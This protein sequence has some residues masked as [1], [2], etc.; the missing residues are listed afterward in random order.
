M[1][2]GTK[3]LIIAFSFGMIAVSFLIGWWAK[4][5]ITNVQSFFGGTGLLGPVT[6]GLSAMSGIASAFAIV[7]IPGIVYALGNSMTFWMLS[8][9]AFA[10]SFMVIGKKIRGMAELGPIASL[11]D[12]SDLRFNNNK[13]IKILLSIVLFVGSIAYLAAQIDACSVLFGHLLGWSPMVAGFVIFGILTLYMVL[14]GEVGGALTQ[15]FQGFVMVVASLVLLISFFAITKGF[16]PVI[17]VVS[18][19]GTV[20][21]GELTKTFIPDSMNAYGFAPG[22]MAMAWM[23]IPIL[24]CVGQPQ[25]LVRMYGINDP[26]QM[27]KSGAIATV[28]HMVVGF[29]A[30]VVGYEALYLVGKGLIP[31]L[32]NGDQAIFAVAD[33]IG[34]YAQLFV[35]A[36]ILA[37][38]MSSASMF[39]SMSSTILSRDL[40]DAFGIKVDPKKQINISR[41][42][43]IVLGILSI[44]FA[45]TSSEMVAILGT[46]GWGTLM[47]ATFPVFIVGLLWKK[48][49]SKGVLS[50]LAV[51]LVLNVG[52]LILSST[53]F[54]WPGG[55]PWYVTVVAAAIVVTVFVSLFTKEELDKRIEAVID[56]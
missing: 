4:R 27:P 55:L 54:N 12:I 50:G 30:V 35:Y 41:V 47:S 26:T 29:F 48:A 3:F 25:V 34:V 45:L 42:T 16:G 23:L 7:G 17:E 37:A 52:S 8:S 36:A 56:L 49:T 6:V 19:A 51:A 2:A 1:T 24:G 39:L 40:P 20:T 21:S 46:F 10:L 33:Y 44:I 31:P 38:A 43:M 28:T 18:N 53:G 11:G 22:T 13:A 9:A 5:K 32:S 14:S 15:A